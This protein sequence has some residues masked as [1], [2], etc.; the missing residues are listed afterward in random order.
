MSKYS[1]VAALGLKIPQQ[2][3]EARGHISDRPVS[4]GEHASFQV[5]NVSNILRRSKFMI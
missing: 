2:E 1:S 3:E 5:K 4:T